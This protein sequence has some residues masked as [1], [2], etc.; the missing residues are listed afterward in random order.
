MQSLH[1]DLHRPHSHCQLQNAH[2]KSDGISTMF[3]PERL[4]CALSKTK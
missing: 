1:R 4:A 2:E 3:L